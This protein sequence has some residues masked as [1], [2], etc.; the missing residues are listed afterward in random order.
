MF[1]TKIS[2]IQT[3]PSSDRFRSNKV[4]DDISPIDGKTKSC[5][6]SHTFDTFV[7]QQHLGEDTNEKRMGHTWDVIRAAAKLKKPAK[8]IGRKVSVRRS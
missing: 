5:D 3:T 6:R 2:T 8:K 7:P 1:S 4:R